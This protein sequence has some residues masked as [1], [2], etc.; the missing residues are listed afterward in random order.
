VDKQRFTHDAFWLHYLRE[1]ARPGTRALHYAG[2]ALVV[3]LAL[4][5]LVTGHWLLF[6]AL[7]VAGYGLAWIAH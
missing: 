3:L 2:T 5:A 7:P 1:H 6:A 4:G